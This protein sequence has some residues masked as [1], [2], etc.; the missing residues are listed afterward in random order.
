M[1]KLW[2]LGCT[3][4]PFNSTEAVNAKYMLP[5]LSTVA[6][7]G[8]DECRK[9][10]AVEE[11]LPHAVQNESTASPVCLLIQHACP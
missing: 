6:R 9:I 8:W 7:V 2:S 11:W 4:T 1:T 10:L 5:L 3:A